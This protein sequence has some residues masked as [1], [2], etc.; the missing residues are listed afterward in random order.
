MKESTG[1][2]LR[3][4]HIAINV[5]VIKCKECEEHKA[6]QEELGSAALTHLPSRTHQPQYGS[7]A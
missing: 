6:E 3:A 1:A 4:Q 7:L 2:F 5:W